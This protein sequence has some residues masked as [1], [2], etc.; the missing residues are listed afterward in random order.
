MA[1]TPV[2]TA[3][4]SANPAP[5]AQ[6]AKTEAPKTSDSSTTTSASSSTSSEQ[7]NFKPQGFES[8]TGEEQPKG[9]VSETPDFDINS[10]LGNEKVLEALKSKLK[11]KIKVDGTEEE[12]DFNELKVG[13]QRAKAAQKRF[14][15]AAKARKEVEQFIAR[16]KSDPVN[17][18]NEM[19]HDFGSLA[20]DFIL[21]QMEKDK[22]TPEEKKILELEEK[23]K[24]YEQEKETVKKAE[25]QAQ[26]QKLLDH[27]EADYTDKISKA[28]SESGLPKTPQT[29][30][31]TAQY[32]SRALDQGYELQPKDVMRYVKQDYMNDI[33]SL[34][35]AAEGE[36]L[37]SLLGEQVTD[38]IRKA[39]LAKVKS[40][41]PV[42]PETP[43][44]V[45]KTEVK[46]DEKPKKKLTMAEFR[47]LMSKDD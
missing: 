40:K 34:F 9:S 8:V 43:K 4:P 20:E 11:E 16:L 46:D 2:N 13:Y 47:E 7:N 38:K 14:D 32:L 36:Q 26:Y 33:M 17:A 25:E 37:M 24:S 21:K 12:V 5:A 44:S 19:G 39:E 35:G 45:A 31:R 29:V 15:E 1:D 18:L 6:P 28:L 41:T 22:L 30:K 10:I 27:Y 23:V 3:T 42:T